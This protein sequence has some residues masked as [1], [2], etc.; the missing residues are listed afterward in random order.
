MLLRRSSSLGGSILVLWLFSLAIAFEYKNTEYSYRSSYEYLSKM[1]LEKGFSTLGVNSKVFSF[2]N[3]PGSF[4]LLTIEND[5]LKFA[6]GELNAYEQISSMSDP[7]LNLSEVGLNILSTEMYKSSDFRISKA[8][9]AI[10]YIHRIVDNLKTKVSQNVS[11]LSSSRLVVEE[12]EV[13]LP[14]NV[15]VKSSPKHIRK[16]LM[17]SSTASHQRNVP[18]RENTQESTSDMSGEQHMV[19]TSQN[20]ELVS[21]NHVSS[22]T[23][24]QKVASKE[25]S[26]SSSEPESVDRSINASSEEG[27]SNEKEDNGYSHKVLLVMG[28][29]CLY[30]EPLEVEAES[31][32]TEVSKLSF[33]D[34]MVIDSLS[35]LSDLILEFT[36]MEID[37]E[38]LVHCT[39]TKSKVL[40]N[41]ITDYLNKVFKGET[42]EEKKRKTLCR[43]R[44]RKLVRKHR[45]RMIRRL[46][47]QLVVKELIEVSPDI[48]KTDRR[49]YCKFYEEN[50][51]NVETSKEDLYSEIKGMADEAFSYMKDHLCICELDFEIINILGSAL[52]SNQKMDLK[53]AFAK[54]SIEKLKYANV[55]ETGFFNKKGKLSFKKIKFNYSSLKDK[56]L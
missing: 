31:S 50:R 3:L 8:R 29:N 12:E 49:Q 21:T 46:I 22:R 24:N 53:D 1:S 2:S 42:E 56:L 23:T 9:E 5:V 6:N 36:G 10:D 43:L 14:K 33:Q 39:I 44:I 40:L 19:S 45:E 17:S 28:E 47:K 32:E 38:D 35:E 52:L 55:I 20:S 18:V 13:V 25:T 51:A 7:D 11:P 54:D 48:C 30:E 34:F 27:K 26:L 41:S 16:S 15:Y 4:P 37:I